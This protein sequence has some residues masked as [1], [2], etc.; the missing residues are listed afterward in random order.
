MVK[1]RWQKYSHIIEDKRRRDRKPREISGCDLWKLRINIYFPSLGLSVVTWWI[2]RLI[3][4][5]THSCF[6]KI[7]VPL[8][9]YGGMTCA[10]ADRY[11]IQKQIRYFYF[12]HVNTV[13]VTHTFTH[14]FKQ[15]QTHTLVFQMHS[16]VEGKI[17]SIDYPC[18][19]CIIFLFVWMYVKVYV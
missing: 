1:S 16:I 13:N 15:T 19:F 17:T 8:H 2:H 12:K 9:V 5:N 10:A 11:T 7:P 14:T 6:S 3:S 4:S 18:S